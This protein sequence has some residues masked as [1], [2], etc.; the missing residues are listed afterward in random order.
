MSDLKPL[1]ACWIVKIYDYLKQQKGLFLNGFD[2]AGITEAIKS[3]NEV[4]VR[5]ENPFTGKRTL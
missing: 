2:E 3:V 4:F 1:H 5:T